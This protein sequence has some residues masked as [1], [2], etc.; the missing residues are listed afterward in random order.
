MRGH[1]EHGLTSVAA[2]R[3]LLTRDDVRIVDEYMT[4]MSAVEFFDMVRFRPDDALP[5]ERQIRNRPN[6]TSSL[7]TT[8][9]YH[10]DMDARGV[11]FCNEWFR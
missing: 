11:L 6:E 7:Y 9:D 2:Y 1:A 10:R 5:G 8:S 4:P 3:A